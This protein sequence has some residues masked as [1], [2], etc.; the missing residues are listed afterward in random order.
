[1]EREKIFS[2]FTAKDYNTQLEE[3]LEKKDFSTDIK[4]L[5][6]SMLYKIEAAYKDYTIV[7]G[8]VDEQNEYIE[9]LLNIIEE[10]CNKIVIAKSG[11]TEAKEIERSKSNY[12]VDE[13]DGSI[14]LMYPNEKILLYTLYMLNDKQIYLDEKYNLVR[15]SLSE[16]L[17]YGENINSTEVLRDFNGWSWNTICSEI[18]DISINLV[19]QN[20]IYLLGIDFIKKWIHTEEVIDYVK[21]VQE[22][23]IKK[24]GKE[25]TNE[26]L[27]QIY[28]ISI[29]ICT[30][31]NEREKER[32]LEEKKDLEVELEKLKDKE[33]LLAEIS[34]FKKD[35]VKKIKEIDNILSNKN[36]L[37][38]EFVTRNEKRSEYNKILNIVHMAEILNKER[39][40]YLIAIEKKNKLLDPKFY[41]QKKK[42]IEIELELLKDIKKSKKV[43]EEKKLQYI[44]Q[45]QKAFIRCFSMEIEEATQKEDIMKLIYGLR[46][47]NLLYISDNKK[48]YEEE[49]LKE[50]LDKLEQELLNKAY[51]LKAVNI[52]ANESSINKKIIENILLTKIISMENISIELIEKE[53]GLE[54]QIYDGDIYEK[55]FVINKYNKNMILVKLKKRI[56]YFNNL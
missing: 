24:Y 51:E 52:I 3:I 42:N 16:L 33:N 41:L 8:I 50:Y 21:V 2:K 15:I 49:Q 26:I 54:V 7:K 22:K 27:R 53:N 56:K 46:Y 11:T 25:N 23:L 40:K 14:L 48:I 1:M 5:L 35:T 6:L 34:N 29:I 47:F 39:K 9:E 43:R 20:L 17:N 44:I 30:S 13:L 37:Y 36:L 38:K 19:Y 32:L 18:P 28:K 31:K 55:S 45:L 10:K 12:I 4:N